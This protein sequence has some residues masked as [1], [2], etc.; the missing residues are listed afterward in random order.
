MLRRGKNKPHKHASPSLVSRIFLVKKE[1]EKLDAICDPLT[2]AETAREIGKH[3]RS[4]E[5]SWN[6]LCMADRRLAPP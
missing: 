2:T 3:G 6:T 5:A 4:S 1:E